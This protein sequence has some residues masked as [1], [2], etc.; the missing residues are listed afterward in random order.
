MILTPDRR[1]RVFISSTLDLLDERAAAR[2]AVDSLNLSSVMFE[3]GARPHP[4]RA[5]YRAYVEQSDVFVAIYATRYGWT[6]PDMDVSGLEDE[7]NLSTQMPRLVYI[8][9]GVD[10]EPHLTQFL[11]RVRDAGLSYRPFATATELERLLKDDLVALLTE[12]FHLGRPDLAVGT[13]QAR[14]LAPLPTPPTALL[15][16]E[17]DVKAVRQELDRAEG[18]LVTLIGPGG[19]GKTRLA[20]ECAWQLEEAF[21][22]GVFF[23]GLEA[24]RDPQLVGDALA[25]GLGV[26]TSDAYPAAR[27][28]ADFVRES[29]MLLVLDNF[30]QVVAAASFVAGLL[31]SCPRLDPGHQPCSAPAARRA[32]VPGGSVAGSRDPG[33]SRWTRV[34]CGRRRPR[35]RA[36]LRRIRPGRAAGLP[37]R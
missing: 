20:I 15:G 22:D 7:F 29:R 26:A 18:G 12:R 14:T 28:V 17:R 37:A 13:E 24:L 11:E 30:E 19:I 6:A 4:P 10:R 32:G 16:R 27:A 2:R 1:L 21:A 31:S 23:V 5:L 34:G 25:V 35:V 36:A 9:T 3:A 8:Q 33:R